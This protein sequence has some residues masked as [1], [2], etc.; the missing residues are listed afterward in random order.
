MLQPKQLTTLLLMFI[1]YSCNNSSKY[2]YAIKD[3]GKKLQPYLV[4]IVDK[5]IV[6]HSDSALRHMATD[7]ELERLGMSEHPIL[8]ATAF[9]EML[10]R[11]SFN[12]FDILM[13]HLDDTA[14][15]F[16]DAG[17]FGIWDR[18]V[19]DDILQEAAWKTKE[20][21][22]KTV[23]QVLTK[24][25]FLRSA[26]IILEDLEPQQKYY[27]FIKDMATRQR[28]V[29]PYGGD[30][31]PFGDLE[32]AL[33]GLSK[34]KRQA[35]IDIIK[36]RLMA[37]I[38]KLSRTSFRLLKEYP[39]TAYFD[40]LQTYHHRQFYKFSGKRP[41]G[42]SGFPSDR[43]A[44]EDF[45]QA[46]V[47]QQNEKSAGLLDTILTY[48]PKYTSLSDK[49]SIINV[50]IEEVWDHP[51]PAY[52]ALRQKIKPKAEELAKWRLSIP[53]DRHEEPIDTTKENYR[54]YP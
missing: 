2:P 52:A 19:S 9:R 23:D 54:W 21:K 43:A 49:E 30:E 38:W 20:A 44:P 3:F 10:Q 41:G 22:A 27:P 12:H 45:I 33:Y 29:D 25:N 8:R 47:A 35:D 40:V 11:K 5:G 1:F 36:Q 13:A 39:D 50:L 46:L 24:H 31:V 28:R 53:I 18:K 34:F 16:T 48:L 4:K 6:M 26:Y 32:Y 37:N 17:E 51:C 42:F 15:V 7:A 14:L